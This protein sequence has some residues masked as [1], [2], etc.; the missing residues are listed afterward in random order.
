VIDL[1]CH[2]LP[3]LDDGPRDFTVSLEMAR[4]AVAEGISTVVCT[5][6][7]LPTVYDNTGTNIRAAV[8]R[9]EAELA[10]AKV[11]LRVLPG[12]DVHIAPNLVEDL[13]RGRVLSIADSRYILLEAPH[14]IFSPALRDC[15]FS[16]MAAGYVPILTHPERLAWIGQYYELL[17]ELATAGT[18]VQITCGSL[19]GHFGRRAQHWSLRMLDEG[20]VDVIAT[21]AH[22]TEGR[23]PRMK[24]ALQVV[25]DHRGG[26]EANKMVSERPRAI[27]DNLDL[28]GLLTRTS[29]KPSSSRHG[30][31]RFWA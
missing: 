31:W 10:R 5:P 24:E 8:N 2:M 1:H 26:D 28:S 16:L 3:G 21:D 25:V 6:H 20:F 4:I 30:Q 22:D 14:H 13:H 11:P 15:I 7:I 27:L 29:N 23:P 9:F 18:L 19:I 17:Q 12:A